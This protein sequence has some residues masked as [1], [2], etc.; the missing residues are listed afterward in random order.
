ML[1]LDE[2]V[3]FFRVVHGIDGAALRLQ[4]GYDLFGFLLGHADIPLT[5]QYQQRR[6]LIA[7]IPQR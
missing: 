6:L 3:T 2:P 7:D 4:Y 5:L 1:S